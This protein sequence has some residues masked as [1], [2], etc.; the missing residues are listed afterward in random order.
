MLPYALPFLASPVPVWLGVLLIP[1][2][3]YLAGASIYINNVTVKETSEKLLARFDPAK[4]KKDIVEFVLF[5]LMVGL[6]G[7]FFL[8]GMALS[9]MFLSH[10]HTF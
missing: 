5:E 3:I 9:S 1:V 6:T 4:V 7:S 8:L 10:T 2:L